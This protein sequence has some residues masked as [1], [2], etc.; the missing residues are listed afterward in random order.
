M[1]DCFVE[2]EILVT[3]TQEKICETTEHAF[4]CVNDGQCDSSCKKKGF[5]SG[6]CNGMH[7]RYRCL[8]HCA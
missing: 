4:S 6:K 2:Y 7:R 5:I 3:S 1:M 8:K